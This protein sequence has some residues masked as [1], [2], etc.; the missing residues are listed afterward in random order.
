MHELEVNIRLF[1]ALQS[2]GKCDNDDSE[3]F[4]G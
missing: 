1:H 2:L 3:C 4:I